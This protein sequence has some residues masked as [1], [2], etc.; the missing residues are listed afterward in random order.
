M[1]QIVTATGHRR[2]TALQV[3]YSSRIIEGTAKSIEDVERIA[4]S[5]ELDLSHLLLAEFDGRPVG[6]LW[7][8][9][10]PDGT[11]FV[12]PPVVA[13]DCVFDNQAASELPT[14]IA[15]EDALLQSAAHR[16]DANQAWIGQSLVEVDQSQS[17]TAFERN[18]FNAMTELRF[19]E[20]PLE[21][22]L[23]ASSKSPKRDVVVYRK[24]HNRLRFSNLIRQT[25]LGSL[26]CPELN[27]V[28]DAA[29]SLRGHEKSGS[30]STGMWRLYRINGQDAGL[31]LMVNRPERQAW[32][33]L[34]TGVAEF[35][36]HRKLG[37]EMLLDGLHAAREVGVE[38]MRVVVDVRNLPA[39]RLYESLGFNEVSSRV[40][41][42]RLR[43]SG[44]QQVLHSERDE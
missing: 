18:G 13:A 15:I 25:Y 41:H 37:R 35:A 42:I 26:D 30:F 38:R 10:Q 2:R 5:G 11:G 32:E 20:R 36:R 22:E 4:S 29:E 28:R 24:S 39:L 7:M 31:L 17:R 6:A 43:D 33:V 40:A 21:H 23:P 34:Y 3:L 16:L 44:H 12:G 19:L 1:L 9:I 14:G 27:H 8:R